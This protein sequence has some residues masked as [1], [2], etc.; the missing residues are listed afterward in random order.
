MMLV[1]EFNPISKSLEGLAIF[2]AIFLVI[3]AVK[4]IAPDTKDSDSKKKNRMVSFLD[5]LLLIGALGL[6]LVIDFTGAWIVL[7]VSL[8]LFLVYALRTRLFKDDTRKLLLPL[9]LI[10]IS[11]FLFIINPIKTNLPREQ[12]LSQG[13][14]WIITANTLT[15]NAK[16]FFLGSGP[17]TFFHSFAKEK[18]ISLNQGESWQLRY[19]RAGNYI[20]ELLT[21]VGLSGFL[22]YAL[23]IGIIAMLAGLLSVSQIPI[24]IIFIS[25]I[26]AQL[27]YYQNSVSGFLFWIMLGLLA[28]N[29]KK[30]VK[31]FSFKNFA[32]LSLIF[33]IV[34]ICLGLLTTFGFYLGAKS[35]YADMAYAKS[36][37]T[38]DLISKRTLLEKAIKFN[39]QAVYYR[40]ILNRVYLNEIAVQINQTLS[41]DESIFFQQKV[42]KAIDN[43]KKASEISPN[44]IIAWENLAMVYRDIK[45][46]AEGALEWGTKAL[47]RALQLDPTNPVLHT[48]LGKLY[49]V[50]SNNDKARQEFEKAIGL[51]LDYIDASLQISLLDEKESKNTEAIKRLE[52][53]ANLYPINTDILFQLGRLYYNDKQT[54]NA[55]NLLERVVRLSPN[56]SNAIYSLAIAYNVKGEKQ[57]AIN[58]LQKVLDLN[59]DNTDL[60]Q[61]MQEWNK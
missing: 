32:E 5:S 29:W 42:A 4:A 21:T 46:V 7:A 54:D 53:L 44:N 36:E 59:P 18:P 30:E 60:I 20:S 24:L 52:E 13:N 25:I 51:K 1:K 48:E 43:A 47:E 15:D 40:A 33:N 34:L 49:L 3:L 61:K 50:S 56:H 35:Y 37:N 11:G 38:N 31:I 12:I 16:N 8:S 19:D 28:T 57:K 41:Q 6:M 58:T 9:F 22:S 55:I 45:T 14:S 39:P 10:I 17:G 23:I 27:S 2:L 26:I